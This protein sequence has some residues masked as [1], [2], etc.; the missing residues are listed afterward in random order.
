MTSTSETT[1]DYAAQLLFP[2]NVQYNVSRLYTIKFL[3][4][5]FTG[6]VAGL[7]GLENW[8]GF[9]L[10]IASTILTS[11]CI[12]VK[13]RGKPQKYMAGGWW[14]LVNPGQENVFSFVLMWTL[15]FGIIHVYD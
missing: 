11:A 1:A 13:V 2:P 7:L 12:Y 3:S 5:C 9:A 15:F 14:E 6:A 8:R 4:S 10:L